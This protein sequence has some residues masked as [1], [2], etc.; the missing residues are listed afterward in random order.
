MKFKLGQPVR[1]DGKD[2]IIVGIRRL[3]D[4]PMYRPLYE[5]MWGT[6]PAG[7]WLHDDEQDVCE[8][9]IEAR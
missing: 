2:A 4:P 1:V 5:I 9:R 3:P 7:S 8:S 6:P